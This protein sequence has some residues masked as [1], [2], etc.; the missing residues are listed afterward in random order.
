MSEKKKDVIAILLLLLVTASVF[1]LLGMWSDVLFGVSKRPATQIE[2]VPDATLSTTTKLTSTTLKNETVTS[3]KDLTTNTSSAT[4]TLSSG[5]AEQ[6][7]TTAVI[8]FP[9]N[10]NT[11]TKEELMSIKGIGET[12]AQRILDY[13][14]E[15]NGFD[16]LEQL[17]EIEGIGEGRFKAWSP[18]LT[19]D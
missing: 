11:A 1:F 12:Y 7:T 9:I 15:I 13:R 5:A 14:D 8:Q 19:L 4:T 10:L 2:Y 3:T 16:Y 17:M 18:Y 6:S